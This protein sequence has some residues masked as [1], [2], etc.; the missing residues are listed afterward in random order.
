[1]Q[2]TSTYKALQVTKFDQ[3]VELKQLDIPKPAKNQVLV[4]IEYA[5]L[6]PVDI[7]FM[8]GLLKSKEPPF[9]VGNEGSGVVVEVGPELEISHK[10]GD[11]VVVVT[12]GTY[13]EYVLAQ[14]GDVFPIL[15]ENSF[16]ESAST[17]TNPMTVMVMTENEVL[18]GGHKAVIHSAGASALGKMLIRHMKEIGVKTINLVRKEDYIKELKELGADY[19]LNMNDPKFEEDL[20]K[21]AKEIEATLC[22][23]CVGGE[24]SG[25]ILNAMPIGGQLVMYGTLSSPVITSLPIAAFQAGK[26]S[27]RGFVMPQTWFGWNVQQRQE[28]MGKCQSKLK[29]SLKTDVAK[30]FKLEEFK[31]ALEFY[32]ANAS[33]G[34]VLLRP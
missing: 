23:E 25:K 33:Q 31:D 9:T 2:T 32:G 13:A 11:R 6:N 8:K 17:W 3:L 5:S 19:V 10:V 27:I 30:V 12:T 21:I 29:T 15:A 28:A 20:A 18:K 22:F 34:K 7:K 14:S 24:L 1:M 4:K 26:K 16:E